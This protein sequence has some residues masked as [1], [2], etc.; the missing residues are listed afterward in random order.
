MHPADHAYGLLK[1]LQELDKPWWKR[2]GKRLG[3]VFGLRI[4]GTSATWAIENWDTI[5]GYVSTLFTFII[6]ATFLVYWLDYL[7]K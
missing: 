5:L 2:Y 1:R 6:V 7:R 3:F 4:V